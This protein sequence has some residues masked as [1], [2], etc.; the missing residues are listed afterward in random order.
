MLGALPTAEAARHADYASS[1]Q[2]TEPF[3]CRFG[4]APSRMREIGLAVR[5]V[6]WQVKQPGP[7]SRLLTA[8]PTERE[9]AGSAASAS[10]GACGANP[11]NNA[12]AESQASPRVALASRLPATRAV[13]A[14]YEVLAPPNSQAAEVVPP[15][16]QA[17]FRRVA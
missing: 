1:R 12:R 10:T 2:L 15:R 8:A 5:T 11:G 17:Y 9:L 13:D 14:L 4:V 6:T 7:L 16:Y 3:R